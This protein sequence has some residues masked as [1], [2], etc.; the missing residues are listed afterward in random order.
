MKLPQNH[1]TMIIPITNI[2][3]E[4]KTINGEHQLIRAK[5]RPV[6]AVRIQVAHRIMIAWSW[7]AND[8]K[9]LKKPTNQLKA[10]KVFWHGVKSKSIMAKVP[11]V[12]DFIENKCR[13]K[14]SLNFVVVYFSLFW[15]HHLI[16]YTVRNERKIIRKHQTNMKSTVDEHLM[17]WLKFGANNCINTIR[18][19]EIV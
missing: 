13:C 8:G 17:D 9:Q 16:L 12:M 10:M 11:L 19:V 5:H 3:Y 4:C 14:L 1:H 18:P 7:C 2:R 15:L 6:H